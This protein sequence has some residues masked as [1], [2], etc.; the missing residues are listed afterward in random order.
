MTSLCVAKRAKLEFEAPVEPSASPAIHLLELP[1]EILSEILVGASRLLQEN[2]PTFRALRAVSPV[3]CEL[4]ESV[5]KRCESH[6][7][8]LS[9]CTVSAERVLADY[10]TA[11]AHRYEWASRLMRDVGR[12]RISLKMPD[13]ALE[14]MK[15]CV[16]DSDKCKF[17]ALEILE[18]GV[19]RPLFVSNMLAS[20][21]GVALRELRLDINV[22]LCEFADALIAKF[23]ATL[24]VIKITSYPRAFRSVIVPNTF[25]KYYDLPKLRVLDTDARKPFLRIKSV[26]VGAEFL[27]RSAWLPFCDPNVLTQFSKV[28]YL[29]DTGCDLFGKMSAHIPLGLEVGKCDLILRLEEAPGILDRLG[30]LFA[31]RRLELSSRAL[32][33]LSLN[34]AYR[35]AKIWDYQNQTEIVLTLPGAEELNTFAFK[36][37]NFWRFVHQVASVT[38]EVNKN[39][40]SSSLENWIDGARRVFGRSAFV[41]ANGAVQV[42]FS[43]TFTADNTLNA[44]ERK[45]V[46]HALLEV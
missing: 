10:S 45:Q 17:E 8:W 5:D 26:A 31:P 29:T 39:V 21:N 42:P 9:T 30:R 27:W 16:F 6:K 46:E 19:Y 38:L 35:L 14:F 15:V 24:E 22:R 36:T 1:L 23:S 41:A 12:L 18:E 32:A 2:R 33:Q 3:L 43:V 28:W 7:N 34:I 4:V 20:L 25:G 37:T 11:D 44:E 40:N 13:A